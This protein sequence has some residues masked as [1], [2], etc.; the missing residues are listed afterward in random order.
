MSVTNC[1]EDPDAK[2]PTRVSLSTLHRSRKSV[3]TSAIASANV[4][5]APSIRST[6]ASVVIG[7]EL[8]HAVAK[9]NKEAVK[10]KPNTITVARQ[11]RQRTLTTINRTC[12]SQANKVHPTVVKPKRPLIVTPKPCVM[13]KTVQV[14]A[15]SKV[16]IF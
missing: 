9:L 4:N 16:C 13:K 15:G 10:S 3:S 5:K 6:R 11:P 1:A 7:R 2:N 12:D 14:S 8:N